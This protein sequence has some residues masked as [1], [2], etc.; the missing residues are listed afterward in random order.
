MGRTGVVAGIVVLTVACAPDDAER[1]K[2]T[3]RE[4]IESVNARDFDALDDLIADNVHR[5]SAATPG[6]TVENLEEF[7]DFLRQDLAAVPDAQ[8]EIHFM[9][10]EDDRVAVYVT[11]RGTQQGQLLVYADARHPATAFPAAVPG[12]DRGSRDLTMEERGLVPETMR[13]TV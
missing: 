7:K 1:N 4:M 9:L 11:Y 3:V 10:A 8:Q 12:P 2:E 13:R 6:V 5:H